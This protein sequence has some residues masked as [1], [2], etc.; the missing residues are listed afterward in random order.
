M[1]LGVAWFAVALATGGL[2]YRWRHKTLRLCALVVCAAATLILAVP[3][4]GEYVPRLLSRAATIF[5]ATAVLTILA[6]L[7]AVRG[8]P[9][10]VSRHDRHAAALVCTAMAGLYLVVGAFLAAAAHD[11]TRAQSLPQLRTRDEFIRWRDS[12]IDPGGVLLEAKVSDAMPALGPPHQPDIVASYRCVAVGPV[13]WSGSGQLPARYLL[14]FPGGPSVL[15][16]GID[17]GDQAWAWHSPPEC[18]LRHGDPLVVWGTLQIGMGGDGPASST[19]LADVRLIAAGDI[20]SFLD[21]Y[22]PAAERTGRAVLALAALNGMLALSVA[23]VGIRAHRRLSRGDGSA[24]RITWR[25]T[26]PHRP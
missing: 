22:V 24:P 14:D 5:A 26:P 23:I 16:A 20:R 18:V 3:L 4:T 8:L 2:A 25:S 17:S 12:P 1:T 13:R 6:T 9:Q 15:A 10:L 7:L 19:G 21:G 11:E